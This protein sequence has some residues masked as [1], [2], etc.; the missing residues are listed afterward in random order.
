VDGIYSFG[1]S[2]SPASQIIVPSAVFD[3]NTELLVVT[4]DPKPSSDP[5][6]SMCNITWLFVGR[7]SDELGFLWTTGRGC[8]GAIYAVNKPRVFLSGADSVTFT[9]DT[10]A[11]VQT[12][13]DTLLAIF[14]DTNATLT[15]P[16]DQFAVTF[17]ATGMG[18]VTLV[19]KLTHGPAEIVLLPDANL[20]FIDAGKQKASILSYM[21]DFSVT[22]FGD[23]LTYDWANQSFQTTNANLAQ[24][25][26]LDPN[27]YGDPVYWVHREWS[28]VN[29]CPGRLVTTLDRHCLAKRLNLTAATPLHFTLLDANVSADA[30]ASLEPHVLIE[31]HAGDLDPPHRY[32]T[33]VW[34]GIPVVLTIGALLLIVAWVFGLFQVFV[35]PMTKEKFTHLPVQDFSLTL[36][37]VVGLLVIPNLQINLQLKFFTTGVHYYILYFLPLCTIAQSRAILTINCFLV[38]FIILGTIL[39]YFLRW[40]G[41]GAGQGIIVIIPYCIRF[42]NVVGLY[43]FSPANFWLYS[44]GD[45]TVILSMFALFFYGASFMWSD[46][47]GMNH[48]DDPS[49][50]MMVDANGSKRMRGSG[51]HETQQHSHLPFWSSLA[52]LKMVLVCAFLK[53]I[54]VPDLS[55]GLIRLVIPVLCICLTALPP[56]KWVE[57]PF[58][59]QKRTCMSLLPIGMI[60]YFRIFFP[61][62]FVVVVVVVVHFRILISSIRLLPVLLV[63]YFIFALVLVLVIA[64]DKPYDS[65]LAVLIIDLLVSYLLFLF[66][67]I[68]YFCGPRGAFREDVD[69]EFALKI[70]THDGAGNRDDFEVEME[71]Q[72]RRSSQNA[73]RAPQ[74]YEPDAYVT[75]DDMPLPDSPRQ[76]NGG[77]GG[78]PPPISMQRNALVA[79]PPHSP[80][81]QHLQQAQQHYSSAAVELDAYD[82]PYGGDA[83]HL[84]PMAP[85]RGRFVSAA[86]ANVGGGGAGRILSTQSMSPRGPRVST[87]LRAAREAL[88][89]DVVA[90]DEDGIEPVNGGAKLVSKISVPRI[91][92]NYSNNNGDSELP[93]PKPLSSRAASPGRTLKTSKD[94]SGG[95]L[96]VSGGG[97][98]Q[99]KITDGSHA[100]SPIAEKLAALSAARRSSSAN[101]TLAM[102]AAQANSYNNNNSINSSPSSSQFSTNNFSSTPS[103][104]SII[105]TP[106][107][108][109]PP[110]LQTFNPSRKSGSFMNL[111]GLDDNLDDTYVLL[112]EHFPGTI[113]GNNETKSDENNNKPELKMNFDRDD[114]ALNTTA[115]VSMIDDIFSGDKSLDVDSMLDKIF[116]L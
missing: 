109:P 61:L 58:S 102:Q 31:L 43:V 8:H 65:F 93:S 17:P 34:N 36:F 96:S 105:H 83:S 4:S 44:G 106:D 19:L 18:V 74:T 29:F 70:R 28:Q 77:S 85:T 6:S 103:R 87:P 63:I 14:S 42:L 3:R 90:L 53:W 94:V 116:D 45:A 24:S 11:L 86:N 7:P 71:A 81:G 84:S 80:R 115:R 67:I 95:G 75:L 46:Y 112:E 111:D 88:P 68:A 2:G 56:L 99:H 27:V 114:S 57:N 78:N 52:F 104:D 47:I 15:L 113:P 9:M 22:L 101:Q 41:K 20:P 59:S 100:L 51:S 30:A 60:D 72:H 54:S 33:N 10:S 107:R 89:S 82:G 23:A 13:T 40:R 37:Y 25:N 35:F 39:Y 49:E 50:F 69:D 5:V 48:K 79:T 76:G 92:T 16:R 32:N 98:R 108:S 73:Y 21:R 91:N 55:S 12:P 62:F 38:I 1:V 97:R 26:C 66:P 64:L 110:E